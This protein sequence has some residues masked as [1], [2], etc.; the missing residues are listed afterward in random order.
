MTEEITQFLDID[1]VTGVAVVSVNGV[2]EETSGLENLDVERFG[3]MVASIAGCC[4]TF[5]DEFDDQFSGGETVFG[6]YS[7]YIWPTTPDQIVA[8]VCRSD[9]D[10]D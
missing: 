9:A 1:S 8:V 4:R 7:V 3:I 10:R 2:V 6:D 5:Q